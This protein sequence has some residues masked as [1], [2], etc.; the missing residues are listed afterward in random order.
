MENKIK[1]MVVDDSL[2]IRLLL[3][4]IIA[5]SSNMEIIESASDPIEAIQKLK[6]VQ[7]DV[8]TLDVEMPHMDGLTFLKKIMA[9][10]PV[11]VVMVS[12]LTAKGSET[13]LKALELGAVDVVGKPSAK[14]EDLNAC[15]EE[16]ILKITEAACAKVKGAKPSTPIVSAIA[17]VVLNS[18]DPVRTVDEVLPRRKAMAVG[19]IRPPLIAIGSSTGGPQAL[20]FLLTNLRDNSLP[21]I[22]IAQHMSLGFMSAFAKRMDSISSLKV[23]EAEENMVLENGHVYVAPA[24]KHLA[25][26][27]KPRGY[28]CHVFDAPPVN[29]HYPSVDVLMRSVA[30]AAGKFALGVILTGMGND[31]AQ[32]LL[33]LKN[34]GAV[35]VAQ[36]EATSIVYGMPRVAK[37][38]NAAMHVAS[39][40]N[41]LN[42]M[43]NTV[44]SDA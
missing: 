36:D 1:V 22:V 9:Q 8:I 19:E 39:L 28:V 13:A 31:G 24:G 32:G 15:T 42:F 11:P 5:Q 41:I 2:S 4:K 33:E 10:K 14:A 37:E 23:V 21:P 26:L 6:T 25:V 16:I 44:K 43:K 18:V 38:M 20:Q 35:T 30:D 17:D 27:F 29:R 7:P 40:E 12:T 34:T 3:K